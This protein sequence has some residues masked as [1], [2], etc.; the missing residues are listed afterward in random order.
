MVGFK[1]E[2]LYI[3][4]R[5]GW[6]VGDYV[7]VILGIW[8]ANDGLPSFLGALGGH[9]QLLEFTTRIRFLIELYIF[10]PSFSLNALSG[11]VE[12]GFPLLR[13]MSLFSLDTF[14]G[15]HQD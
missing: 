7:W 15:F 9:C 4:A 11:F 12:I 3:L 13:G 1:K 10:C 14:E 8:S 6:Q 2:K 5:S